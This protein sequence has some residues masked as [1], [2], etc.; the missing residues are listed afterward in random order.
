MS[1][2]INTQ[3]NRADFRWRLLTTVSSLALL[4][5]VSG[6]R[7]ARAEDTDRPIVWIELGADM[8]RVDAGQQAFTPP[9]VANNPGSTAFDPISPAE[10]QRSPGF[11][12]GADSKIL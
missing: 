9:F 6:V 8:G 4:A 7:D 1:E 5:S 10:A 11:G 2:L 12:F 3:R